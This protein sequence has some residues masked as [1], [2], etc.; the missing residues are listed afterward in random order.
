MFI[1][2]EVPNEPSKGT[3]RPDYLKLMAARRSGGDST[4]ELG[5]DLDNDGDLEIVIVNMGEGPSLLKNVAPHTGNSLLVR[6][7][8][9]GRDAIGARITLTAG[10]HKQIEEVRSGGSFIS[11]S[12]F[13][14]HFGLG[15]AT[16]ADIS[17][18]WPDGKSE[19]FA[20][21]AAGQIVTIE[22]GKGIIRKQQ[23][24]SPRK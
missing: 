5:G 17:V 9:S 14:V 7:L 1:T 24:T 8:T 15:K 2:Y 13:R 23:F 3:S 21:I 19:N 6:A 4:G 12:D 20:G 22:E 11:Q 10:S 18:R 16:A